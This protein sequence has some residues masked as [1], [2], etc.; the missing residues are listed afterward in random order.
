MKAEISI[1][2]VT[3]TVREENWSEVVREILEMDTRLFQ[4]AK[5]WNFYRRARACNDI[6]VMYDGY[7]NGKMGV[8][9]NL[10]GQGCRVWEKFHAADILT[11]IKKLVDMPTV[12][13]TRLDIACDD[14]NGALDMDEIL[15][16]TR[17][18]RCRKK[19]RE[20]CCYESLEGEMGKTVYFGSASSDFRLKFYDK[21]KQFYKVEDAGYLS[22]W[23]RMEATFR[24][25][26]ADSA[27]CLLTAAPDIPGS[28]VSGLINRRF[29]F[30]NRDDSNISRCSLCEWWADFLGDI[31]DV[32]L[33]SKPKPIHG[34]ERHLEWLQRTCGRTIA[35]VM[36]TV[37]EDRFFREIVKYGHDRLTNADWLSIKDYRNMH[38]MSAWEPAFDRYSG[39]SKGLD[40]EGDVR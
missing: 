39:K 18:G 40:G 21:A 5:S 25:L 26:Q 19:S 16:L 14:K 20:V 32:K 10:S 13:I 27:A 9:V 37:G 38:G 8:C 29:A 4:D 28:I 34:I 7:G 22:H 2:Y 35:K 36:M 12:K 30:V 17:E 24:G 6:R 31:A 15:R 3:F 23:I 33:F 1:D 11:L